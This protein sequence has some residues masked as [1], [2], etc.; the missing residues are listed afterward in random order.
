MRGHRDAGATRPVTREHGPSDARGAAGSARGAGAGGRGRPRATRWTGVPG[1]GG[2]GTAGDEG[3]DGEIVAPHH[4]DGSPPFDV[5]RSDTGKVTLAFPGSGAR[6]QHFSRSGRA[7]ASRRWKGHGRRRVGAPAPRGGPEGPDRPCPRLRDSASVTA[8]PHVT[9]RRWAG[10]N[11][12][13]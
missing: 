7:A 10:W 4:E 12:P 8:D 11:P 2:G 6:V 5:R 1:C 9:E 13:W 3:R